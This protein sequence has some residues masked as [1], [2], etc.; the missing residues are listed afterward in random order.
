MGMTRLRGYPVGYSN[1]GVDV[2]LIGGGGVVV[3]C[4]DGERERCCGDKAK[5]W[6]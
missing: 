2:P 5:R 6:A 1:L 4:H 3:F